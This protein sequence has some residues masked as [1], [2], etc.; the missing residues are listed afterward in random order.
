MCI[1]VKDITHWK[2]RSDT[3]N[4][5]KIETGRYAR[6]SLAPASAQSRYSVDVRAHW[7]YLHPKMP[8]KLERQLRPHTTQASVYR[9]PRTGKSLPRHRPH[10]SHAI[11]GEA[12]AELVHHDEGNA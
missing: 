4:R 9:N 10:T 1:A 7:S 6:S 8:I 5:I 2:T 11:V 3:E 12:L